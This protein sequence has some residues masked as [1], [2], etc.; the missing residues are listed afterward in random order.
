MIYVIA[1]LRNYRQLAR[2]RADG[3]AALE[4][5]LAAALGSLAS[6]ARPVGQ[7]VWLAEMGPEEDLDVGVAAAAAS[8]IR[9]FLAG[10]RSEL[11][12]FS[13]LLAPL[14]QGP[15]GVSAARVQKLLESAEDD[16]QLWIAPECA[17]LFADCFSFETSGLLYRVIGV[18]LTPEREEQ[19]PETLRPWTRESLVTR[20][21]DI[22]S[23][24]LNLGEGRDI[25]WVHGP[26]GVG[27]TALLGELA[28]R[29]L[30]PGAVPA[31]R[32][33]T[34]FKR[35]SPLHPFLSSLNPAVLANTASRLR[36]PERASWDD[37]GPL[38][39]WLQEPAGQGGGADPHPLPDRILDDFFLGYRLYLLA[40]VRMAAETLNPALFL[41]EG[42]DGYHP[43]ARQIITRLFDDL[44]SNTGLV[45]VVSSL[46]RPSPA[47]LAGFD[48]HLLYVHPLGKREIR[49][50]AQHLF[51]GLSM[52]ES[53]TRRL[54]RRS[55]GLYFSVV[56]YLQ[57]LAKTGRIRS[58]LH[59]H[60]WGIGA[61]D[62]P[63]LPANPLSVSWFLIRTLRDDTF[64]LLYGLYLAGGL[65]DRQGFLSF[66]G[67]AGFDAATVGRS[68]ADLMASGLMADER[69]LIPRFPTLRRKL[70]E[71]LGREGAALRQRFITHMTSLWES[72]RYRHPVL[73]F[74]FLARSGSTDLALRILPEII[75]RKL[76]ECDPAGAA[77]FCDPRALEFSVPPTAEQA[78]ELAAVTALGR[79]RAA[80][81]ERDEEAAQAAQE[82]AKRLAGSELRPSLRG[83]VLI[84][85][86]KYFLSGG[87]AT[88][89][90]DELKRALLLYQESR[91]E[92]PEVP[93]ERGERACYLWLGAA[94]LAEG[95]LGEA[96][97]YLALSQRLC[98]EA[99]DA[100]GMLW[101]LAYL[102][103]SLFIDGLFTQCLSVIEQGLAEARKLFRREVELFLLFLRARTRFQVGAYDECSLDLQSCLCCATLYSLDDALPVLR[104]WLG[105]TFLHRDEGASGTRLLESLSRQTREVLLFQAEGC[106]FSGALENASLYIERALALSTE[107]RFP[108]PEGITWQD[109][110]SPVEG[111]CFK[112]SRGSAL[113]QRTLLGMRAYLLGLR[114]FRDEGIREL[115]QL[116]RGQKS[117]DE[118]PRAAWFNYLYSQV[119]P[120]AG[121]EEV[122]DKVTVLSKS[123]KTLQERASRIDAPGE[124]S[125]FLW[126]NRWNRMIMEEARNRKLV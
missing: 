25:L 59:G 78:K 101:T 29:L 53:L 88:A 15:D 100:P 118:D 83:E 115:H 46:S 16:E 5:S 79:L 55:G 42:I 75:R 104:A 40:W 3:L 119:L 107:S 8:R 26:S 85:R 9:D 60:E 20:A 84:E 22:I 123:L 49:S 13:V 64:L 96:V 113:L 87:N 82:E 34:I 71:L 98:Y 36:G 38:L 21:L 121:S 54:R 117:L 86:A 32:M 52:P 103:G 10:R 91:G 102:A 66:L 31:L 108:A 69:D 14:Q 77:A 65:L 70:E 120:E 17:A 106:L 57:Y 1:E 93:P 24:R 97:E 47:D 99:H 48:L 76:D 112:L 56:S 81:L 27:K 114:G 58:T 51:P 111:R 62:E 7:G 94:M 67:E 61:D 124:R 6:P 11:F 73:L 126:R 116:T 30:R 23:P 35:R 37:V 95:R 41:C 43:A 125:S 72:G 33:R 63:A 2:L 74:S 92:N 50:L 122:D 28:A 4:A 109:G 110:F 89:A 68:L 19:A 45:P 44:L 80:L 90:L 12:G 18:R 105:R 39:A